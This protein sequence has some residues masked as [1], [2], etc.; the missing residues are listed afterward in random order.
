VRMGQ[1]V[2]EFWRQRGHREPR[3][4]CPDVSLPAV[5]DDRRISAAQGLW[6][7]ARI[8]GNVEAGRG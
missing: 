4:V 6:P 1:Q 8:A 5:L 3:G 2:W 7:F